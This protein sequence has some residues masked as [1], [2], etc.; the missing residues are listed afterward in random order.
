ML[1]DRAILRQ[2][3]SLHNKDAAN[4]KTQSEVTYDGTACPMAERLNSFEK[5]FAQLEN[6]VGLKKTV[7]ST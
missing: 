7:F 2:A 6:A 4:C 1:I 5:A 3:N